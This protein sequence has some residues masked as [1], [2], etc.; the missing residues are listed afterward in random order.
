MKNFFVLGIGLIIMLVVWFSTTMSTTAKSSVAVTLS[1]TPTPINVSS[2][3]FSSPEVVGGE[4]ATP[5]SWPWQVALVRHSATP[6]FTTVNLNNRPKC[7]GAL[8][9]EKWVITAAHCLIDH[10]TRQFPASHLYLDAVVGMYDLDSPSSGYQQIEID[11]GGVRIHPDYR[12]CDTPE[13]SNV[14]NG[15]KCR[16]GDNDIALLKL[17]TAVSIGGQGATKTGIIS[18]AETNLGNLASTIAY[19]TGWGRAGTWHYPT[20]LHTVDLEIRANCGSWNV[21][22]RAIC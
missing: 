18:L 21:N 9:H 11:E 1:E 22:N 3:S 4:E 17:K 10:K 12:G 7:G 13:W 8:I 6:P 15:Y 16:G 20:K 5:G 14:I 2:S 19:V